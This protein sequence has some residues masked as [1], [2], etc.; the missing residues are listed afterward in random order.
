MAITTSDS[1]LENGRRS[2]RAKLPRK[3]AACCARQAANAL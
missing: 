2:K 1:R 3:A